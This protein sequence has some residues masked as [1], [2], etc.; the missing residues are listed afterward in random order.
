[1]RGI[2]RLTNALNIYL[3]RRK[4]LPFGVDHAWDVSDFFGKTRAVRTVMDV[5]ANVGELSRYYR[6][7]F[8]AAMIHAF[9]PVPATCAR[10]KANTRN[11]KRICLHPIALGAAP[12][13]T[14]M[15]LSVESGSNSLVPA[16]QQ[17]YAA[18]AGETEVRIE[19]LDRFMKQELVNRIDL[20]KIDTEGYDLEVLRGATEA[21]NQRKIIAIYVEVDF[22]EDSCRHTRFADVESF[23]KDYGFCLT[24]FYDFGMHTVP[25]KIEFCNALFFNLSALDEILADQTGKLVSR[26]HLRY[27]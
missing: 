21:L 23:L 27:Q 26:R 11:M 25:G 3:V 7:R 12:E 20:L 13:T 6:L 19:T 14:R 10:F 24:G 18:L 2:K 5:G 9:E 17:A 16:N 22:R 8:P 15:P 1:M 4:W